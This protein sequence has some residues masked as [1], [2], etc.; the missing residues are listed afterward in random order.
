MKLFELP[1]Q[2]TGTGATIMLKNLLDLSVADQSDK[3]APHFLKLK[4]NLLE[5]WFS[6]DRPIAFASRAY[7]EA[8]VLMGSSHNSDMHA[9]KAAHTIRNCYGSSGYKSMR[10]EQKFHKLLADE[11]KKEIIHT[12]SE[13]MSSTLG[14]D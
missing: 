6:F 13:V 10:S 3:Y 7:R 14:V 8:A 1:E 11:V 12:S 9:H 2:D 5:I 4:I